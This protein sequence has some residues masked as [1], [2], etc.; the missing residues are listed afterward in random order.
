[1]A[2]TGRPKKNIDH[3]QFESLCG[4]QCTLEEICGWFGITD[5][6]LNSWCKKT[7]NKT[8]SEV[9]KEKRSTGKISLRRHQW[10]LAEKNANMAIWLGKQYL[11]Q[12]DQVE[13]TIA[14]G[15]VQDDGLSASLRE[16]ARSLKSDGDQ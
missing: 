10:R 7:Y 8:F 11:G 12:K 1:M 13:T 16:L 2:R 15:T 14:E 9:F 5:K 6:T 3:K 4:L